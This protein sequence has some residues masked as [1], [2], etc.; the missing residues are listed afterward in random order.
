M[1]LKRPDA[2]YIKMSVK[3]PD[4]KY[5]KISEYRPDAKFVKSRLTWKTRDTQQNLKH[6]SSPFLVQKFQPLI[7]WI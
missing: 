3:R 4:A 2:K 5:V 1:S 7:P 6:R